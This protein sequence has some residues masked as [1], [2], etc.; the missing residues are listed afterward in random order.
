MANRDVARHLSRTG[1]AVAALMVAF[2]TTVGVGVMVDSFRGG[3]AIWINDLLNAD[4]YIAPPAMEDGGDRSD[5]P[6]GAG[7]AAGYA[8]QWR[9]SPPIAGQEWNWTAAPDP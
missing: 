5:S 7:G 4:L 8:R 2:A 6:G 9:R 1:I 3:V